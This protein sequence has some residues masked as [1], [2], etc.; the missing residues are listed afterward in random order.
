M[1]AGF[2]PML[3]FPWTVLGLEVDV[4]AGGDA[5]GCVVAPA[6]QFRGGPLGSM[7]FLRRRFRLYA[8]T[9]LNSRGALAWDIAD[10]VLWEN[11]VR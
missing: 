8:P 5:G 10:M 6:V 2:S 9:N 4:L 1:F 11:E 3:S 7:S